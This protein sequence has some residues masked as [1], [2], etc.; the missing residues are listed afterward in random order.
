[1]AQIRKNYTE[2]TYEDDEEVVSPQG[3]GLFPKTRRYIRRHPFISTVVIGLVGFILSRVLSNSLRKNCIDQNGKSKSGFS[4]G[5]IFP[6][7]DIIGHA[8][9]RI[10]GALSSDKQYDYA[11]GTVIDKK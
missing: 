4:C 9:E 11:T 7:T 1:M 5:V 10:R 2:D 8:P 3:R 6:I